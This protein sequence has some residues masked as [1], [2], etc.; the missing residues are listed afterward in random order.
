MFSNSALH[1]IKNH[2][3]LL[4]RVLRALKDGGICRFNFPGKGNCS[5][6]NDMVQE[7]MAQARYSVY[8]SGFEWPWYIPD[9]EDCRQFLL[10]FP[11]S[12]VQAW[13]ENADRFFPDAETMIRWID[14]PCLAPFLPRVTVIEREGF[15]ADVVH[16][17][18]NATQRDNGKHFEQ[19][20]RV[21]VL[22][23]K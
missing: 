17:M 16:R 3:V 21:H 6:F 5:T 8:F 12:E 23:R 22:A 7:T 14:Q 18:L 11:F 19:F 20:R 1:W 4:T 10:Q 13:G 15:R 9:T 2:K